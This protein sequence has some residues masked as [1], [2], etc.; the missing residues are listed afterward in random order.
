[1]SYSAVV[2]QAV[3]MNPDID[4]D[5]VFAMLGIILSSKK[6]LGDDEYIIN[7]NVATHM[8]LGRNPNKS[9]MAHFKNGFQE[10]INQ[11]LIELKFDFDQYTS[12]IVAPF[13]NQ[14]IKKGEIWTRI[15]LEAIHKIMGLDSVNCR[16]VLRLYIAMVFARNA[17]KS[18]GEY[19]FKI[20]TSTQGYFAKKLNL[21]YRTIS[22]YIELLRRLN[23]I[24]LARPK[25]EKG[26]EKGLQCYY[27]LYEDYQSLRDFVNET[28]K[29]Y[30]IE[31]YKD[32]ELAQDEIDGLHLRKYIA[33]YTWMKRGKEYPLEEVA[34][35]KKAIEWYN[36][37][38]LEYYNRCLEE[39]VECELV[40]KN[41]S[42]FK[43]YDLSEYEDVKPKRIFD[44]DTFNPESSV[45]S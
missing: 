27:A 3:V 14:T 13:C 2:R 12:V 6:Y 34:E 33:K 4:G 29:K 40:Q 42:V 26:T 30:H 17:S 35:I 8:L 22:K 5:G 37:R 10:L 43:K 1:M 18:M 19:R 15:P 41:M 9:E 24:I 36:K 45:G 28:G 38:N 11:G 16:D 32:S 23:L 25:Y 31:Y 7:I 44:L 39:G 21:N 20:I